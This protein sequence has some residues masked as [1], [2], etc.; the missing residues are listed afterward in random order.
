M[1]NEDYK[2]NIFKL[3]ADGL[4]WVM[5]QNCMKY[6]LDMH[7]WARHLVSTVITQEYKDASNIGGMKPEVCWK[8]N[9]AVVRQL[10][11]A[12]VPDS[13]FNCIKG[14]ANAKSIWDELKKIF[15]GCTR[16]LLIDLG[17]KL[18]NMKC[19]EDDDIHA[20]FKSLANF[21]KQLVAMG[22]IISDDQYMNMLMSS[23]PSSYD[24]NIS[25]IT[26]NADMSSTSIT[27]TTVICIIMDEYDKCLL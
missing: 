24:A 1:M 16:N 17:R 12:S 9:E 6:A 8:T 23:L 21:H 25:I 3:A 27:P 13:V 4:N 15:E 7:R 14:G 11:I 10:I 20:H 2:I 22:Q 18:Q 26:T 5:Y 19:G